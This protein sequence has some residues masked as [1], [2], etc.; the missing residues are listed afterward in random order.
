MV[1]ITMWLTL[2]SG[3]SMDLRVVVGGAIF[4]GSRVLG[5]RVMMV[6]TIIGGDDV[7]VDGTR[8]C[9]GSSDGCWI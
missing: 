7:D 2:S 9:K 3:G 6:G 4:P 8:C 1:A 5:W